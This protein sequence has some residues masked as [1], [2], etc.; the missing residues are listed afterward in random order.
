MSRYATFPQIDLTYTPLLSASNIETTKTGTKKEGKEPT[1]DYMKRIIKF[2]HKLDRRIRTGYGSFKKEGDTDDEGDDEFIHLGED[3]TDGE[4]VK[5][6]E[7]ASALAAAGGGEKVNSED[8]ASVS[9]LPPVPK[10]TDVTICVSHAASL[11]LVGVLTNC[12][13]LSE[14]GV[15]APC[16]VF[17]LRKDFSDSRNGRWVVVKTGEV[18][19]APNFDMYGKLSNELETKPW[20]FKSTHGPSWKEAMSLQK[21]EGDLIYHLVSEEN[22]TT[23]ISSEAVFFYA[24]PVIDQ[25]LDEDM[26]NDGGFIRA[27]N[28]IEEVLV[29]ANKKYGLKENFDKTKFL[30]I[31]IDASFL[32]RTGIKVEYNQHASEG[33]VWGNGGDFPHIYGKLCL[34]SIVRVGKMVRKNEEGGRFAEVKFGSAD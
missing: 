28:N 1:L 4:D 3:D 8:N 22:W 9:S 17:K 16:G 14:L 25:F 32:R 20:G 12:R 23:A 30:C 21:W 33:G 26:K 15:F 5:I 7:L 6:Q 11:S 13:D 18:S 27:C 19:T 24:P 2:G 34:D 31:E 10:K 29:G